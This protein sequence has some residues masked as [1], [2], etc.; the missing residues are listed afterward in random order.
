M[1]SR[2]VPGA[3]HSKTI[4]DERYRPVG[5]LPE[6]EWHAVKRYLEYLRNM[7][8]PLIRALM[9]AP[10]D[11]EPTTAEEDKGAAEAWQEHLG[12]ASRLKS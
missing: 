11:D 10:Y 4:K 9:E 12:G 6:G 3:V 5:E 8:D 7:G 1:A 2:K